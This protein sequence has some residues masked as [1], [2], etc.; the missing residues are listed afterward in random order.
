MPR[1]KSIIPKPKK[2]FSKQVKL[3]MIGIISE[4][5]GAGFGDSLYLSPYR[6]DEQMIEEIAEAI[7]EKKSAVAQKFLHLALHASLNEKMRKTASRTARLAD[8]Q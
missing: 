5:L 3:K 8:C 2:D 6:V 4:I 7:G 1:I